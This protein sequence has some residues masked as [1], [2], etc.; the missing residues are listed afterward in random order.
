MTRNLNHYKNTKL[1]HLSNH[2]RNWVFEKEKNLAFQ[3]T[4]NEKIITLGSLG[5]LLRHSDKAVRHLSNLPDWNCS[6]ASCAK[7]RVTDMTASSSAAEAE[8]SRF[9]AVDDGDEDEAIGESINQSPG[10]NKPYLNTQIP[11]KQ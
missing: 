2:F 3:K 4:K 6:N 1:N 8:P 5:F 10:T 9:A 7:T 11:Q